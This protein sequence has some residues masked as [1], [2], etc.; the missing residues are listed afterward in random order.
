MVYAD[1]TR[2]HIVLDLILVYVDASDTTM[3]ARGRF[4]DIIIG[5]TSGVF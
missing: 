4:Q 2:E 3:I 1:Q 5:P